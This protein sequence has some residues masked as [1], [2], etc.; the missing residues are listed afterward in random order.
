MNDLY[1]GSF[2]MNKKYPIENSIYR[3][4]DKVIIVLIHE[5]KVYYT[6]KVGYVCK[7][8]ITNGTMNFSYIYRLNEKT[9]LEKFR[10]CG[11]IF[12]DHIPSIRI[13]RAD[14]LLVEIHY[15]MVKVNFMNQLNNGLK[16]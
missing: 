1:I 16:I 13:S 11:S 2:W 9:F 12:W 5:S 8:E 15:T 4:H 3:N 7:G 10:P 14:R 6:K